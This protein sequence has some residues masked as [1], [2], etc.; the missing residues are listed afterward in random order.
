MKFYRDRLISDVV[1]VVPE[2]IPDNRG[3]FAR[4]FC[5]DE[6]AQ[7]GLINYYP[8]SNISTNKY[9]G[10]LRGMHYQLPPYAE[11]K[12]ISCV[13]G[14][15]YDVAVD[16]RSKSPTFTKWVG[17][18]LGEEDDMAAL[19]I[20][21]GFAHGYLTLTDNTSVFYRVSTPY[22]SKAEQGVMWNDPIFNI[23]WPIEPI[24]V[25]ARDSNH[26]CYRWQE[27]IELNGD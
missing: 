19:Y 7:A 22:T 27:G 23:K 14:R 17:Y 4:T 1:L 6:L 5:N 13:K 18:Y 21:P 2:P 12:L 11:A 20:P 16:L 3:T 24:I 10:I 9:A 15:I 8:Q 25:S 26:E